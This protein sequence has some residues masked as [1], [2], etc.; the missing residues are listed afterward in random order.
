MMG[1]KMRIPNRMMGSAADTN[2]SLPLTTDAPIPVQP[3]NTPEDKKKNIDTAFDDLMN[4]YKWWCLGFKLWGFSLFVAFLHFVMF[5]TT[6]SYSLDTYIRNKTDTKMYF[7]TTYQIG[8]W[9]PSDAPR[10]VQDAYFG[11]YNDKA[12]VVNNETCP[13]FGNSDSLTSKFGVRILTFNGDT[14][15][16]VDFM[17]SCFF[18]LSWT[19]QMMHA[20]DYDKYKNTLIDGKTIKGHFIEYSISAVL[21]FIC[22]TVELGVTNIHQ[23]A[24]IAAS[25]FACMMLGYA[26]EILDEYE[27]IEL[28]G[29]IKDK[30]V[31]ISKVKVVTIFNS[32]CLC[33]PFQGYQ[34]QIDKSAQDTEKLNG[35]FEYFNASKCCDQ[36]LFC[37]SCK[38]TF[39]CNCT[40]SGS[41]FCLFGDGFLHSLG[42]MFCGN[43]CVK[44][45]IHYA[46]WITLGLSFYS[47]INPFT[48]YTTCISGISPPSW[49]T[50]VLGLEIFLFLS[51][52][53]VQFGTLILKSE[54]QRNHSNDSNMYMR[55]ACCTEYC[56]ILLSIM[57]KL[58][59]GISVFIVTY[60]KM[61]NN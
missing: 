43:W 33:L 58:T 13:A 12:V 8:V 14:R 52:G 45:I 36:N 7:N 39:C 49:L 31:D 21:L 18:F 55:V 59:L 19:F 34:T 44:W 40:D 2:T 32:Q 15:L 61:N 37:E 48:Q 47:A 3:D 54:I 6:F 27:R 4:H 42:D 35:F 46:G 26:A 30:S 22:M 11:Y 9:I 5:I 24:A 41:L 56:Y 50:P 57:A 25:V 1:I 23:L 20:W 29:T 17:I 16:A 53:L 51:F 28:N 38:P 60:M 10:Y